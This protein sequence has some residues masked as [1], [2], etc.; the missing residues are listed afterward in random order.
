MSSLQDDPNVLGSNVT[1]DGKAYCWYDKLQAHS[2]CRD[3]NADN[4]VSIGKFMLNLLK[5]REKNTY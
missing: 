3:E 1:V 5:S 4:G 2:W